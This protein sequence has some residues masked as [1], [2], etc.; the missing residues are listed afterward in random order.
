MAMFKSVCLF[1]LIY[2]AFCQLWA[3]QTSQREGSGYRGTRTMSC[4]FS[5]E[6]TGSFKCPVYSTNTWNLGLKSHPNDM[7]R[8]GIELTTPGFTV[9]SATPRPWSA[10]QKCSCDLFIFNNILQNCYAQ[11]CIHTMTS[12]FLTYYRIAMFKSTYIL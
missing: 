2:V 11:K 3:N 12:S 1:V 7:V 9:Q 5:N 10:S 4:S 6:T 8:R